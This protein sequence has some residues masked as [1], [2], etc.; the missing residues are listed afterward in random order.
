MSHRDARLTVHGRRLLIER[1]LAG[2]PVAHVAAE[3]RRRRAEDPGVPVKRLLEEIR[4]DQR[5]TSG[6]GLPPDLRRGAGRGRL[7]PG[8]FGAAP[9]AAPLGSAGR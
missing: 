4:G 6:G 5:L 9:G 1:V 7:G 2:R 3:M 8:A